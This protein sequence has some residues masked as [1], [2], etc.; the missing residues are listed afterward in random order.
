MYPSIKAVKYIHK[1]IYK[2]HDLATVEVG[3]EINKI[4]DYIDGHY[5][6][7]SEACWHTFEFPMHKES[8][9]VYCLPVHLKDQ[10]I[11]FFNPGNEAEDVTNHALNK[12]TQLMAW[13]KANQSIPE[14]NNYLYH[15]FPQKMVWK[16]KEKKWAV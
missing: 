13:F 6:G 5:I 2:G 7:P 14:A 8:P 12:D 1:Y 9:T 3:Q 16:E 4:K 15:N 11:V 10:Q